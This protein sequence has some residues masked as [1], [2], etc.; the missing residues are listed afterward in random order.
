[1]WVSVIP[2][3]AS[4][5]QQKSCALVAWTQEGLQV[6]RIGSWMNWICMCTCKYTC[7]YVNNLHIQVHNKHIHYLF[8]LEYLAKF[9][10]IYIH[11]ILHAH[12]LVQNCH[13]ELWSGVYPTCKNSPVHLT[14]M[15]VRSEGN[16]QCS[17]WLKVAEAFSSNK[18][19]LRKKCR[20]WWT[21]NGVGVLGL[22]LFPCQNVIKIDSRY[23]IC[24]DG[25]YTL[26]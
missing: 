24:S 1:M 26:V 8:V 25:S 9:L 5:L 11:T 6:I 15:R 16:S 4:K 7:T 2:N 12:T 23:V 18:I 19:R 14:G 20:K 10:Y 17:F 21:K 22:S 13:C 3:L